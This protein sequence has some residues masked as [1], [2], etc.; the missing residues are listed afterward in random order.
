MARVPR[1]LPRATQID[2][3]SKQDQFLLS[4]VDGVLDVHEL[5]FVTGRS[6]PVVEDALDR[7]ARAGA[8]AIEPRVAPEPGPLDAAWDDEEIDLEPERRREVRALHDSLVGLDDHALL[9]VAPGASKAEIR[10]AY[11]RLA[12]SYHPDRHFRRKLGSYKKRIEEVFIRITQAYESLVGRAAAEP[13]ARAPAPSRIPEPR[14]RMTSAPEIA[15]AAR[16]TEPR[17]RVTSAPESAGTDAAAQR[18]QRPPPDAASERARREALAQKLLRGRGVGAGSSAPVPPRTGSDP[19]L[20]ADGGRRTSHTRVKAVGDD[21]AAE[22]A[23]APRCRQA[24]ERGYEAVSRGDDRAAA[25]AFAEASALAPDDAELRR[26]AVGAANK[27]RA[28]GLGR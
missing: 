1:P 22:R 23:R 16:I 7:M 15:R 5:C 10:A 14:P 13:A 6:L 2:R 21:A 17:P 9:G 27:A 20:E 8:L 28:V 25:A 4:L 26:L 11:H 19:G 18:T 24:L 12:A 3:F